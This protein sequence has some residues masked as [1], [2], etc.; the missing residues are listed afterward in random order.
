[1]QF[2]YEQFDPRR[3]SVDELYRRLRG[4]FRYLL[5]ATSGDV[6]EALEWLQRVARQHG[7]FRRDLTF[8]DFKDRLLA[9][10]EIARTK[11]GLQVT[12]QGLIEIRRDA[13]QHVFRGLTARGLGDHHASGTGGGS[14]RL[15]ETR[16]YVFGDELRD[17]DYRSSIKNAM[18]RGDVEDLALTERDVEVFESEPSTSCATVILVDISHSMIL[19]GEDR[20]TPAKQVALAMVE[21]IKT[22][23][24]RDAVRVAVFGDRARE[25]SIAELPLLRVGP[26]HT[27]TRE[28]LELAAQVLARE[29]AANKQIFLVTDGKPSA[30]T[31][32]RRLYK[33][34]MGLDRQIVNKTLETAATLRRKGIVV[35]TF[36][37]T[38]EP[39]LVAFVD[40]FTKL[41]RGRAYYSTPD[42]LGR[43]LLVDYIRNRRRHVS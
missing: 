5:L 31:I 23:Y 12:A 17:I 25:I 40:D 27:N 15:P 29:K 20:I 42:R 1:M 24:P 6:E 26:F 9:D 14:E 21:L 32:G 2:V 22:R 36:M 18:K 13:L 3:L 10:G 39:S 8:A 34:P 38:E 37:L 28:G 16:P 35:T 33:N 41:N 43:F 30:L 19:Y 4:L 11:D 7:L